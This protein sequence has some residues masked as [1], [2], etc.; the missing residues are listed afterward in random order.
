MINVD[1]LWVSLHVRG[2]TP[3]TAHV[4]GLGNPQKDNLMDNHNYPKSAVN[5]SSFYRILFQ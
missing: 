2:G 4:H 1:W 5:V 3:L